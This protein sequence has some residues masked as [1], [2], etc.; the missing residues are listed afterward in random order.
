MDTIIQT[1]IVLGGTLCLAVPFGL[2]MARMISYEIR[3]LERTLAIVENGFYKLVGIDT[4]RQMTWKEYLFALLLTDGIVG[5]IFFII[6]SVQNILPLAT[7]G[8]ENFSVDLAFMQAVSFITNTNLQHYIGDQQLSNLS[9]MIAVTFVM[10]V[11]PASAIATSF[12]FIRAFI[13]KNFGLGNFYV[14]FTR[15][16]ITLL[17]P[18]AFISSILLMVLGVPQ[19]LDSSFTVNTLEGNEQVITT[20]PVASLESIKELGNN[21][22]GFF[23]SNSAHPFENPNGLSNAY[24]I[25][26]IMIIPLSLPIAFAKLVGKGRGFHF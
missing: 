11:A 1:A 6:V 21:G 13:R 5:A 12:A 18:V 10:F 7:P 16:N 23:G 8:L 15:I 26:L 22:G 9:Q 2:Y 24:E 3:P 17:L 14:D 25:F 20:G 4:S 19:T